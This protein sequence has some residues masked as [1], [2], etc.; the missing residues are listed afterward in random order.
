MVMINI[1][2]NSLMVGTCDDVTMFDAFD[3][4]GVKE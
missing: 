4:L 2:F 1:K 3:Q